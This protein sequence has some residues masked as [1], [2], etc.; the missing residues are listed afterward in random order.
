VGVEMAA[1]ATAV[2]V[3]FV[4]ACLH[5][6]VGPVKGNNSMP[7]VTLLVSLQS[8]SGLGC[9]LR[10]LGCVRTYADC[11]CMP[12]QPRRSFTQNGATHCCGCWALEGVRGR[13]MY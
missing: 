6:H 7:W 9:F 10:M 12:M 8:S 3:A 2:C 11:F 5:R 4:V 13:S 1:H